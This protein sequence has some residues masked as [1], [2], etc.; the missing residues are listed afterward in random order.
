MDI[1]NE[2]DLV[3]RLLKRAEI[4]RQIQTRKSVQEGKPDRIADLLEEAAAE[5]SKLRQYDFDTA[6]NKLDDIIRAYHGR[7]GTYCYHYSSF[8]LH[9]WDPCLEREMTKEQWESISDIDCDDD[10][11]VRIIWTDN[12]NSYDSYCVPLKEILEWNKQNET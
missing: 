6:I 10:R 5:I 11:I 7:N 9:P 12:S 4:R 2:N 8:E 3:Y 1:K